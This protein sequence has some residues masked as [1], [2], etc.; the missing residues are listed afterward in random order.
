MDLEGPGGQTKAFQPRFERQEMR[1]LE[2]L[3]REALEWGG[4]VLMAL[5][6]VY[7]AMG[8]AAHWP[9]VDWLRGLGVVLERGSG[10]RAVEQRGLLDAGLKVRPS[11][12]GPRL[13]HWLGMRVEPLIPAA[14]SPAIV[15]VALCF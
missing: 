13:E 12:M 11:L 4:L 7:L 3:G 5:V 8:A 14:K 1:G 9:E 6:R 10:R 2:L 15:E